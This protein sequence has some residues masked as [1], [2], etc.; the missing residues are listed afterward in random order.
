MSYTKISKPSTTWESTQKFAI[1]FLL[2]QDGSYLLLQDESK[3][4]VQ[5]V[6]DNNYTKVAKTS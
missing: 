6:L 2:L 5:E 3:C 4:I 1:G